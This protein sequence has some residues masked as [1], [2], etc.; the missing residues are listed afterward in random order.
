MISPKWQ[1]KWGNP[2]LPLSYDKTPGKYVVIMTDGKNHPNQSDDPYSEKEVD[3]QLLRECQAMKQ[4]GIT[5]FAITFK[6]GGALTSLYQQC[7][8]KPEFEFDAESEADLESVFSTIGELL[9]AGTV[10]LI[11]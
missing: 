11:R 6:M 1:G 9:T 7:A 4:E 10:R 8:S 5:I 3:A 2:N